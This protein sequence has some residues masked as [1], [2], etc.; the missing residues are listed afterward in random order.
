VIREPDR[1]KTLQECVKTETNSYVQAECAR[2]LSGEV[3]SPLT[4]PTKELVALLES[5]DA[6][7]RRSG[8]RLILN[9]SQ[10][11]PGDD[12]LESALYHRLDDPDTRV[13]LLTSALYLRRSLV[14]SPFAIE[15]SPP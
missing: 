12:L 15:E 14:V 13:R 3:R 7:Q 4:K 1:Q 6:E 2:L 9:S 10:T 8:L 5:D 11:A